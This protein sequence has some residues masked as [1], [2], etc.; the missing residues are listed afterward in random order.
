MDAEPVMRNAMNF[1]IAMPTFAASAAKIDRRPVVLA[2][3][4]RRLAGPGRSAGTGGWSE[5]TGG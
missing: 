2:A 1:V 4:L 3:G 5:G